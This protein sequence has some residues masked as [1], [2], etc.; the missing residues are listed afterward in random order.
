MIFFPAIDLKEGRCVRLIKGDMARATVFENSPAEQAK[1][2]ENAGCK[3]LH[4]VDLDGAFAGEPINSSAVTRIIES[5]DLKIELGGGIREL[6]TI[7]FWLSKG[8]SRVILGTAALKNPELVRHACR[9]FPEKIVVGVDAK[10]GFVAVEGWSKIV[11][12]RAIDLAQ[13]YE[14][15]GVAAII[16]TDIDRDGLMKG[17]NVESTISLAN[18]INTPVIAS[19][20]VS[21]M[22]DLENIMRLG[23]DIL[24][25]VISGRAI[26]DGIINPESAVNLLQENH[27][28]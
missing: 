25:G 17:P 16:H 14:D 22:H 24:E 27:D 10:N 9:E 28:A 5:T 20:G 23:A 8:V 21:S 26:Y 19:G 3:W 18:Q 15:A 12:T 7:E 1:I 11:K 2:F 4:V 6:K 13:S